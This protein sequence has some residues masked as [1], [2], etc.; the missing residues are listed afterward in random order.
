MPDPSSAFSPETYAARRR[1]LAAAVGD[2]LI[3]LP[4]NGPAP[5]N[6][7]GNVYP[8]RQDGSF[9]YYAGLDEPGL[10]L[11]IDASSGD[12]TL[13]GHDPTMDDLVWEGHAESL[14]DRAARAGVRRTA[15]PEAL[16][17]AVEAAR[18][19]GR[20]ADARAVFAA[21]RTGATWADVILSRAA[22]QLAAAAAALQ[23]IVDPE[24]VVIGGGVGLA[25]GF[26]ERLEAALQA[27]P[28]FLVPVLARAELGVDAGIVGAADLAGRS[29]S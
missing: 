17:G 29:E 4:G 14:A 2:G 10:A 21:A 13:Y 8:F 6:Y 7:A 5:M 23:A 18:A 12:A 1:E 9:L 19:A 27:Y 24:C 20:D 25:E 15:S 22:D 16:T 11:T 26:L 3:L 28:S